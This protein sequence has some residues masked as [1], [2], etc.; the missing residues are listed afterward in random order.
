MFHAAE[1]LPAGD[2]RLRA[3]DAKI[4]EPGGAGQPRVVVLILP[5]KKICSW[6]FGI[7]RSEG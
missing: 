3:T 7:C 5:L 6:V 4:W 1:G 2:V